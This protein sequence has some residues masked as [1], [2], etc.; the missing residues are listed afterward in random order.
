MD[1]F[2]CRQE[3]IDRNYILYCEHGKIPSY[4]L[5]EDIDIES[6]S[7]KE[8]YD[9]WHGYFLNIRKTENIKEWN[10]PNGVEVEY[11]ERINNPKELI[12]EWKKYLE[13]KV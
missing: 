5:W 4:C 8:R 2:T 10:H 12:S 11:V 13:T 7:M 3:S 1:K 9:W 6:N